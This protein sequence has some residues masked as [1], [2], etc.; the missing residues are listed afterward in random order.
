VVAGALALVL[1]LVLAP[2]WVLGPGFS[3]ARMMRKKKLEKKS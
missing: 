1:A 3:P 2:V